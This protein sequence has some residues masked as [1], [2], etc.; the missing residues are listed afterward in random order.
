MLSKSQMNIK[1]GFFDLFHRETIE[2]PHLKRF[3]AVFDQICAAAA[4]IKEHITLHTLI[5]RNSSFF[6]YSI[7]MSFG[8]ILYVWRMK[9]L[10]LLFY[11]L[12]CCLLLLG[13]LSIFGYPC[14]PCL[15]CY[16]FCCTLLWVIIIL[17]THV[18]VAVVV[19]VVN[20]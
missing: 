7:L 9:R 20:S 10:L 2:N 13:L 11:V 18:F 14:D 8:N 6:H 16:W 5:Q 19:V 15:Y 4:V 12:K 1:K 17:L 3:S